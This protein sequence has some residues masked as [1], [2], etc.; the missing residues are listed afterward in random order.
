VTVSSAN[1]I[2]TL[3][4]LV[5]NPENHYVNLHTAVNP[6]GAVR[7]QLR[8]ANTTLASVGNVISA[9]SDVNLRTVAPGGLMTIFGSNLIKV[10]S[11]V[12]G[13]M[14]GGT[15]PTTMNGTEVTIGSLKAPILVATSDYIV[16]QV[17]MDMASG[18]QPVVVKNSNGSAPTLAPVTVPVAAT[19]P[20]LFADGQGGLLLKNSDYSIV[21]SN[22]PARA[23]DIVIIYSTGLGVTTPAL[24]TGQ[25]TPTGSTL[26]NTAPVTVTIGGQNARVVYS[27]ASPGYAGLY[28]TAVAVPSGAGTGSVPVVVRMG[29]TT[30]NTVTT[31]LQ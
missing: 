30:S 26:Y 18:N 17:P 11:D 16:A 13:A 3:N 15:L 6:G 4:S 9:V 14:P 10:Q 19:A 29:D 2:A 25:I 12:V 7:A 22:N 21:R 27:I 20:A 31:F 1:G 23:G 24:R 8:A 28:Q 5:Q